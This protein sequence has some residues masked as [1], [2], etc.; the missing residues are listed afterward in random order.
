[1]DE[2]F[3]SRDILNLIFSHLKPLSDKPRA[4][5]VCRKFCGEL[6]EPEYN[7]RRGWLLW[8]HSFSRSFTAALPQSCWSKCGSCLHVVSTQDK[9]AI[10]LRPGCDHFRRL[11][12]LVR[13]VPRREWD[14][15]TWKVDTIHLRSLIDQVYRSEPDVLSPQ[16]L[17]ALRKLDDPGPAAPN[18][19]AACGADPARD[20]SR[21]GGLAL[22]A[23]RRPEL[24]A[25]ESAMAKE[26]QRLAAIEPRYRR[27]KEALLELHAVLR[28]ASTRR[29]SRAGPDER[30]AELRRLRESIGTAI[31]NGAPAGLAVLEQAESLR[32]RLEDEE[33]QAE[34]E[35]RRVAARRARERLRQACVDAGALLDAYTGGDGAEGAFAPFGGYYG[36]RQQL[37]AAVDEA[38]AAGIGEE[39]VP[40]NFDDLRQRLLDLHNHARRQERERREEAERLAAEAAAALEL[41][42]AART[43][44]VP[45]CAAPHDRQPGR[46]CSEWVSFSRVK[47]ASALRLRR[48]IEAARRCQAFGRP[49]L[50]QAAIEMEARLR[51][52]EWRRLTE[53]CV[54]LERALMR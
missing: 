16:Y 34:Q 6:S 2:V 5:M 52:A 15:P 22:M 23:A 32:A 46:T 39:D 18:G 31:A 49:W 8:R 41:E 4:A 44:M 24:L 36:L 25:R 38:V 9:S 21:F 7:A 17:E 45:S 48:S 28:A 1:M 27:R 19:V 43:F 12:A 11:L 30:A 37:D 26:E 10:T 14:P 47:A 53:A 35:R 20:Y 13:Q 33:E 3:G 40:S 50:L 51:D 29:T 42:S 54:L